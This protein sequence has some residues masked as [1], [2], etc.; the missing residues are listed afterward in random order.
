MEETK[1]GSVRTIREL[2]ENRGIAARQAQS[3]D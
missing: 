2:G 1:G 3:M